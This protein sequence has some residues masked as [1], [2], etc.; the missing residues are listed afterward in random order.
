MSTLTLVF[1]LALLA[2]FLFALAAFLQQR[3]A[4]T[5]EDRS[6]SIVRGAAGLMARLVRNRTWLSGWLV[7]IAGFL[8]QAVALRLGSVAAVQPVMATQLLFAL[9]MSSLER[10][11]RPRLRDWA[12]AG[13]I[14]GGLAVLLLVVEGAPLAGAAHRPR[15]V[16]AALS[17][18]VMVVLL[19]IIA[20]RVRRP[21]ASV[22][23]AAAAGLCFAMSSVF[24]KLTADDLVDHGVGF[25]ARDWVGYSLAVSTLLGLVLEQSAFATGSL[26]WSVATMNAVNPVA[27]YVAGLLAFDVAVPTDP[28]T[29]A[30]IT[31]AGLLVVVGV[32]GL[33][34]SPSSALWLTPPPAAQPSVTARSA[35]R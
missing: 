22:L 33:A 21:V 20:G 10:K 27:S 32:L 1:P 25:T 8:A 14:C 4:R 3:A 30:G 12:S 28:A 2:A 19:V 31:G 7:N 13:A 16:L 9:P 24:M 11:E 15:V 29:L 17:A 18:V 23:V 26:P 5:V 34:H 35:R 6:R